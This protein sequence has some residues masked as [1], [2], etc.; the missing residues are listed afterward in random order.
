MTK[1]TRTLLLGLTLAFTAGAI[2]CGG[3]NR[4]NNGAIKKP[5]DAS[6]D[7]DTGIVDLDSGVPPSGD[8][9][10]PPPA[11]SGV[12][13]QD[14]GMNP[15]PDGGM[16]P[17]PDGGGMGFDGGM[18]QGD[19]FNPSALAGE[20]ATAICAFRARCEPALFAFFQQNEAQCRTDVAEQLVAFWPAYAE[21]IS[22][23]RA[24]FRRAGFDSCVQAY[25]NADCIV[26]VAPNACEGMFQG[27]RPVGVA[28]GAQIECAQGSWCALTAL[29]G[30]G[31]CTDR[32]GVG[33]DCSNNLCETTMDCFDVGQATPQCAPIN[34][35]ENGACATIQTGLCQGHLQC[36]GPEAGPFTCVRPAGAG[37]AC[38]PTG[39]GT[40]RT[41][42]IYQNQVCVEPG[43]T[44]QTA[45]F[46]APGAMC[47]GAAQ[48]DS[49]SAG[50]SNTD[51]TCVALPGAG[52]ACLQVSQTEFACDAN[53]YCDNTTTCQALVPAGQTCM[54][55]T[56]CDNSLYCVNNSCGVLDW[57]LCN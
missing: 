30:C 25:N 14:S 53:S 48:C 16:N 26:G 51:M 47:G 52:L 10:T 33:E 54:A 39:A 32:A 34:A 4:D 20:Y 6:T 41:C 18:L 55:S 37:Q 57:A 29:G 9:G 3:D 56:E 27:N 2:A 40:A 38:D 22:A 12:P 36:I 23:N 13:P 42:N 15:P 31:V 50:C 46:G 11:D 35:Q 24:A 49:R 21:A 17:P 44:C 28:C 1:C 19:P 45:S 43:N 8:S 7:T 5:R